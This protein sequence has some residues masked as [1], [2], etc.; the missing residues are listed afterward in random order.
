[1]ES[2]TYWNEFMDIL[3]KSENITILKFPEKK[4]KT[5][6]IKV[7]CNKREHEFEK[8]VYEVFQNILKN[9][10]IFYCYICAKID[11]E[12]KC[13]RNEEKNSNYHSSEILVDEN[14]FVDE[15]GKK[16]KKLLNE[17]ANYEVSEYGDVKSKVSK[18]ILKPELNNGYHRITLSTGSRNSKRKILLHQ[19]VAICFLDNYD[20]NQYSI[21]HLDRNKINNHYTNL[22]QCSMKDNNQNRKSI[23]RNIVKEEEEIEDEVW[24]PYKTKNNIEIEISNLGRIKSN[25]GRI[26]KGTMTNK[27]YYKFYDFLVHRLVAYAFFECPEDSENLVVNHKDGVKTNNRIENLEWTTPKENAI[28]GLNLETSDKVRSVEQWFETRLIAKYP[29]IRIASDITLIN[30]SNIE[31]SLNNSMRCRAGGYYWK[32]SDK[33]IFDVWKDDTLNEENFTKKIG[34]LSPK[35]ISM[36]DMEGRLLNEFKNMSEASR[37]TGISIEEIKFG[38]INNKPVGIYIFDFIE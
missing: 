36:R 16:W 1:M 22:F 4:L 38:A 15:S 9:S 33:K 21:D 8:P 18:K 3:N 6:R 14:I 13:L 7:C 11:N 30:R 34:N 17:Y 35:P 23:E 24:I 28:H 25:N 2:N 31:N 5:Y 26:T 12:I 29:S 19:L 20:K 32:Y 10:N 27:G 37:E